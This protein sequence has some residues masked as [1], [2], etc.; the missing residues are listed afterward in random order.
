[1]REEFRADSI[2]FTERNE[3]GF[4]EALK[5]A[6][7]L[8]DAEVFDVDGARLGRVMKSYVEGGKI[9]G[10]QVRVDRNIQGA[11]GFPDRTVDIALDWVA[12]IQDDGVHLK[13]PAAQVMRPE[14]EAKR[15]KGH[16]SGAA[17]KPRKVR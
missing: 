5:Q 13:R 14:E 6:V 9:T 7:R 12:G 11:L 15:H 10:C 17:G 2:G 8:E 4:E 16:E 3:P 1:M